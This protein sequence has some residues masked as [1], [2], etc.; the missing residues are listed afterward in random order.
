MKKISALLTL[1]LGALMLSGTAFAAEANESHEKMTMGAFE[2][3]VVDNGVRAEFQ[4]MSL[5]QM[6]M[7]DAKGAT[8][9]VMVR[10]FQD[11]T[12][13]PITEAEGKIKVIGPDQ[14]S[15]V[16]DLE[17][18]NGVFAAKISFSQKGKYGVICLVKINEKKHLFK[19]WYHNM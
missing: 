5:A 18:Y 19:F 1:M 13:H 7:K 12:N 6:N 3:K 10:L 17:N 16:A 8:H 2:H 11:E 14:K 9:H 15:Q 4:I